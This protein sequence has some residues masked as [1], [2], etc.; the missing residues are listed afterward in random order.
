MIRVTEEVLCWNILW[1][2]IFFL[3]G[4]QK[5]KQTHALKGLKTLKHESH[6]HVVG[7]VARLML[8][9]VVQNVNEP[10]IN[11]LASAAPVIQNICV[12]TYAQLLILMQAL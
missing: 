2:F 7:L 8:F 10:Q 12:V 1:K 5:G 4:E 11:V 6:C 9:N 3:R